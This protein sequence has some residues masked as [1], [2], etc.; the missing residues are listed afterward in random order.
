MAKIREWNQ[1][2]LLIFFFIPPYSTEL[3][4]IE[5]LWRGIKYQRLPFDAY[6]C[7][8]NFKECLS[9]IVSNFGFLIST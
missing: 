3:N 4:L 9:Y 6:L 5:I 8:Q 2:D 7:F 1:K